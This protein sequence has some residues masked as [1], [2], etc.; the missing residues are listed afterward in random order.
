M[1]DETFNALDTAKSDA[2]RLA[3]EVVGKLVCQG[4]LAFNL[5]DR[6]WIDKFETCVTEIAKVLAE[7][8]DKK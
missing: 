6:N 3:F 8:V 4:A 7:S 5:E 1:S 2:L